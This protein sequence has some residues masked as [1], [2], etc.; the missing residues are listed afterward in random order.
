[1]DPADHFQTTTRPI[2]GPHA[3]KPEIMLVKI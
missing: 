1:L 2:H 3:T